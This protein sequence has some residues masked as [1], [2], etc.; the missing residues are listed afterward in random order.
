MHI[1]KKAVASIVVS[2]DVVLLV[3]SEVSRYSQYDY[4]KLRITVQR[5]SRRTTRKA[6]EASSATEA[7]FARS[8]THIVQ[9][10][11]EIWRGATATGR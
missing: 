7:S 11:L 9:I 10:K 3:F 1:C 8:Q 4:K 5:T 2:K 6:S